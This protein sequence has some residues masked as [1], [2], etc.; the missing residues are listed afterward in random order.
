MQDLPSGERLVVT[1]N[2]RDAHLSMFLSLCWS[3]VDEIEEDEVD[4]P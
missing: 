3:D 4:W 1:T 2:S